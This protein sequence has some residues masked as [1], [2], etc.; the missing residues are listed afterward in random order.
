MKKTDKIQKSY[1][2]LE[3]LNSGE[4]RTIRILAEYYEPLKRLKRNG[5][6]DTVVFFGSARLME[7]TAAEKNLK[8]VIAEEKGKKRPDNN[9]IRIAQ[10]Y[11]TNSHY[12]EDAVELSR[13]LTEWSLTQP[14]GKRFTIC[15]GGGPGIM[16]AANKGAK[17]GG[18]QSI[19][20]NISLP[21]EQFVNTYVEPQNAFEFHY[22][23]MRKFWFVYLAKALAVFPGGFGTLDEFSEI[24]TLVQ[25]EKVKKDIKIIAYD[26]KYWKDVI[27]FENLIEYGMISPKDMKLFDF[28]SSVDEAFEKLTSHF[29]KVYKL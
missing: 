15:S 3:F 23:F 8:K 27:N 28:C 14:E 12:Y 4:A 7:K 9:K 11:V 2:N 18:G 13:R 20:L 24:L 17:L 6:K 10:N 1:K 21:F 25:T 16:E 29:K 22:F 19:G 26:E 5:I